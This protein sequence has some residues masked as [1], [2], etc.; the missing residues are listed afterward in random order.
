MN[1]EDAIRSSRTTSEGVTWDEKLFSIHHHFAALKLSRVARRF[2]RARGERLA[3]RQLREIK[4]QHTILIEAE[5][6]PLRKSHE[7]A[8]ALARYSLKK[9]AEAQSQAA[10]LRKKLEEVLKQNNHNSNNNEKETNRN[11]NNKPRSFY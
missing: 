3:L 1:V 8:V 11:S 10:L 4:E 6:V 7:E 9:A 5:Y 2:I